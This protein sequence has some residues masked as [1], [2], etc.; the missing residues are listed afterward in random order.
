MRSTLLRA[1]AIAVCLATTSVLAQKQLSLIT[2]ITD[3]NGGEVA[4][5]D[6]KE[7]RVLENDVAATIVKVEPVERVPKLQVLVD[8]GSGMPA[9]S[10]GDLRNG[11]RGL[12]EAVPEGVEMTI[13]T[14]APQPRFL[15]RPTTDKKAALDSLNRLA[16][17]SGAGRFVESLAEATQR[18]ERDKQQ[19]ANYTIVTVGTSSG[20]ANVRESDVKQTMERLQK[21]R[22][23][24][25]VVMLTTQVGR[26]ASGGVVQAEL[27]QAAAQG[28]GGRYENINVANRVATLLPEIGTELG[29][30]LGKGS[31]QFRVTFDRPGGAS[32]DL[33]KVSIGVSGKVVANVTL[34]RR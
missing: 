18:I 24:V 10:L 9:A 33:G 12:L 3:P 28:T 8:N 31:R 1:T 26:T 29:K 20:D 32:G 17:D 14:T 7:V 13:V 15:L 19:D 34:D 2:T 11:L 16:P 6:P 27:G 23:V 21:F 4:T 25:H 30:T 5:I 22:P